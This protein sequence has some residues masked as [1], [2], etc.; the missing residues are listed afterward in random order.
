M[1]LPPEVISYLGENAAAQGAPAPGP[2]DDLFKSG[3]LDSFTLVDFVTL[4]EEHCGIKVPD[5]DVRA[6][7]FR[8]VEAVGRYVES[9]GGGGA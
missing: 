6:E 3:V 7:N 1:N 9:R 2:A 8:T 4:L 5:A